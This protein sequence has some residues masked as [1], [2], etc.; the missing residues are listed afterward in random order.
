MKQKKQPTYRPKKRIGTTIIPLITLTILVGIISAVLAGVWQVMDS[1]E[2]ITPE[3]IA[4]QT[5]PRPS[6]N[7]AP[8]SESVPP[9]AS[10]SQP[11]ESEPAP[12]SASTVEEYEVPKGD[13][14]KTDYFDDA[15]F[16]GDSLTD[17]IKGYGVMSN[18]TVISHTGINIYNIFTKEVVKSGDN[19]IT[20]LAAARE[21]SFGKIYLMMG[22]NGG[23]SVDKDEFARGYASVVD[24]LVEMHPDAILY[25]QPILPVTEAYAKANPD[26]DNKR[27]DEYNT[28]LRR[29]AKERELPFVD[30]A[31]ALK[32]ENGA[33]PS[34]ASPKDGMHFGKS[35][36]EMWFDYLRSH[37]VTK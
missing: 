32:D 16:I 28:E 17:G 24:A 22:A 13:W 36:Y 10:S 20:M 5:A 26:Y 7:P 34:E 2:Y 30:V 27:I 18:A 25:I 37:T 1:T 12:S 33:L 11:A 35:Y 4:S 14:V 31:D 19:K 15:L 21:G 8:P 6:Q 9:P 3:M 23:M 29:I